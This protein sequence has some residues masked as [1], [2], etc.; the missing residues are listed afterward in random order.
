MFC[1]LVFTVGEPSE[2][3]GS[4]VLSS[5]AIDSTVF[6]PA[7]PINFYSQADIKHFLNGLN[8]G[9]WDSEANGNG[10]IYTLYQF[11]NTKELVLTGKDS[12]NED[13][14]IEF[15]EEDCTDDLVD[16][17]SC[18]DCF[19]R[20]VAL[21]DVCE[22]E[23][24]NSCVY[25]NEIGFNEHK[26]NDILTSDYTDASDFINK[27]EVAAVKEMTDEIYSFIHPK[28]KLNNIIR[29]DRLGYL[30]PNLLSKTSEGG[31]VGI[32]MQL[33]NNG[34]IDVLPQSISLNVNYTGNVSVQVWD[35]M[36]NIL[37][38]TIVVPCQ[39]KK[40]NKVDV[41]SVFKSNKE[42]MQV[43]FVYD[44][45]GID[46]YNTLIKSSSCSSCNGS[47]YNC[48]YFTSYGIQIDA[49]DN[50]LEENINLKSHTSGL[51][52]DLTIQCNHER[53]LCTL[54]PLTK[55]ARLYKTASKI[56]RHAILKS[57]SQRVSNTAT[58]NAESLQQEAAFYEAEYFK[59][60]QAVFQ[61]LTYPKDTKCFVC[62]SRVIII[63]SPT[64]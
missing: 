21:R 22:P 30:Q 24:L 10:V 40:L 55:I 13:V 33:R 25:L 58:V 46:S 64:A 48:E 35:A 31:K 16:E 61:N 59:R 29:T 11:D 4:L 6:S 45:T 12:A 57:K 9:Q 8:V 44:S 41:S 23:N 26:I 42:L 37:L 36:R 47:K 60:M 1:S 27:M 28:L 7:A 63:N 14:E 17:T 15:E 19:G 56:I 43:A 34:Y 53:W 5:L 49:S 62:N 50:V 3:G 2:Y 38:K 32:L 18:L 20:V 39:P 54:N 52:V 51:M